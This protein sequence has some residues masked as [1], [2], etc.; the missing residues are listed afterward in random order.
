VDNPDMFLSA[1]QGPLSLTGA[2]GR[3]KRSTG[4]RLH[5]LSTWAKVFGTLCAK[6]FRSAAEPKAQEGKAAVSLGQYLEKI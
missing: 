4:V 3:V 5:G 2:N 1:I 6:I